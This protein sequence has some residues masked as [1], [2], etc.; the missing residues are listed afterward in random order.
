MPENEVIF[1]FSLWF[2]GGGHICLAVGSDA[3]SVLVLTR[4]RVYAFGPGGKLTSLGCPKLSCSREQIYFGP[5]STYI[6]SREQTY[7]GSEQI[8]FGA[9]QHK[10]GS[11]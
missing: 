9:E 10:F 4:V 7:F 5:E 8:Y 6:Y 11:E 3:E 2:W 1:M